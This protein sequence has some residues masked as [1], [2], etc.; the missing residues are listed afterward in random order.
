MAVYD[1]GRNIWIRSNRLGKGSIRRYP[2]PSLSP[3]VVVLSWLRVLWYPQAFR[4]YLA[5]NRCRF[6]TCLSKHRTDQPPPPG[7][8]FDWTRISKSLSIFPEELAAGPQDPVYPRALVW[9]CTGTPF[10]V[11]QASGFRCN[12]WHF[13]GPR[14]ESLMSLSDLGAAVGE[15]R[16]WCALTPLVLCPTRSSLGL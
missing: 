2:V 15:R 12:T 14:T 1:R 10:F 5:V 13:V 3:T 8:L 9:S 6:F 11:P 7:P 4:R 16:F